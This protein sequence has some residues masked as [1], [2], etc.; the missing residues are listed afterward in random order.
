MRVWSIDGVSFL[1]AHSTPEVRGGC[2]TCEGGRSV[3]VGSV[4]VGECERGSVRVSPSSLRAHSA[5]GVRG[6]CQTVA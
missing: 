2:Q 6:G 5:P 4:R 3:R 1:R